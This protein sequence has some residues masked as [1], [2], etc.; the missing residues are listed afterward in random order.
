MLDEFREAMQSA[1]DFYLCVG[2]CYVICIKANF[3]TLMDLPS[4]YIN[5]QGAS[6]KGLYCYSL[7]QRCKGV[8]FFSAWAN[9]ASVATTKHYQNWRKILDE[10]LM[11]GCQVVMVEA[12]IKQSCFRH[13]TTGEGISVEELQRARHAYMRQIIIPLQSNPNLIHKDLA[14]QEGYDSKHIIDQ[15]PTKSPWHLST[16]AIKKIT[17][18]YVKTVVSGRDRADFLKL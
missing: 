3:I 2:S 10:L 15:L 5:F 8:F 17:R 6:D 7:L 14:E 9:I 11:I 16:Q 1:T 4:Y 12:P 18:Y 13:P